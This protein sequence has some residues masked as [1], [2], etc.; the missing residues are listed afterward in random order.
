MTRKLTYSSFLFLIVT[1]TACGQSRPN[2][3]D[4]FFEF[5][6]SYQE[7]SLRNILTDDFQ[8]NRTY[9]TYSNDKSSFLDEY[10][11]NSKAYNGKYKILKV[12]S[13]IEPKQFLVEDQSDYFKYLNVDYPTWKITIYT[14]D[15]KINLV[16][17]DTTDTY[18]KYLAN[19]KIADE[20]F[21]TWLKSNYPDITQEMLYNQE[22]LL[23]N[24][25]KEYAEKNK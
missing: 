18:K 7:D 24:R 11:P 3:S 2:A 21:M 25:L 16:S 17:I 4:K 23:A 1:L 9:T 22:G 10:V 13:E 15:N 5:L 12:I 6:N 19:I 20:L 14:K 8:L